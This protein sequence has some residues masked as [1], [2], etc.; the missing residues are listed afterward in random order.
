M[1]TL[2]AKPAGEKKTD[3]EAKKRKPVKAQPRDNKVGGIF[4]SKVVAIW[5]KIFG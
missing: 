4:S 1:G 2:G 5:K 3:K